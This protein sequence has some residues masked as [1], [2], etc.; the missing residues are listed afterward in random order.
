MSWGR[1]GKQNKK[2]GNLRGRKNKA[3]PEFDS[4]NGNNLSFIQ[5]KNG[6]LNWRI[7]EMQKKLFCLLFLGVNEEE[8]ENKRNDT[9]YSK[10]RKWARVETRAS[11]D[12]KQKSNSRDG[13]TYFLLFQN[14]IFVFVGMQDE[15]TRP[16]VHWGASPE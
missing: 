5:K 2:W 8:G 6:N 4:K 12:R 11:K 9:F 13:M 15:A 10:K 1:G 14:S 3:R 7:F 16:N